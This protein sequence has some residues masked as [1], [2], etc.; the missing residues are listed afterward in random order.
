[1]VR[2]RVINE[3]YDLSS[4]GFHNKRMYI[5]VVRKGKHVYACQNGSSYYGINL[6]WQSAQFP[7][8][9]QRLLR[10]DDILPPSNLTFMDGELRGIR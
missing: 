4:K 3:L 5:F 7:D 9:D 8:V 2:L 10:H 1:M 6:E